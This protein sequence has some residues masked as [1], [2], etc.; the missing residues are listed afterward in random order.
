MENKDTIQG[1]LDRIVYRNKENGFSVFI[2]K[3][4]KKESITVTGCLPSVHD[5]EF[6]VLEGRWGFHKKFGRQFQA[7]SCK[8]KLPSN[9]VGIKKYLGSG[10]IKGIG[11]K[12]AEKLVAVFAEKVLEVIDKEPSRLFEVDGVGPKRVKAI[13]NAWQ[14][15]KEIS[16]IM[17]FLHAR[18]V[19]TAFAVK[20]YK[21]YGQDSIAKIQNNPYQLVEDVWGVGFKTAD[22][23][24]MKLGFEK[25][26]LFRVRAGILYS[27]TES[28]SNGHLYIEIPELKKNVYKVLELEKTQQ[29]IVRDALHDLY[30][31]EKIK[32]ITYSEK[33]FITL[34]Q[35]YFSEKGI[36]NKIKRLNEFGGLYSKFDI[37]SCYQMV[38]KQDEN[39]V[40]LN[41]DQQRGVL[42]CL[43]NK[44]TVITGGPG[45]G[46]TTLIKKLLQV[47]ETYKIKFR[48]AAPTGRAAKRMFE[49]TGRSTETLHRLLEFSPQVM[50]FTRNEQNALDVE[51]VIVDEASMIDLFLMHA[52]LRALPLNAHLIL[53]GDVDQLPSVGVGNILN[54]LILSKKI[55]IIR[56]MHIFRQAQDSLIIVN[57]HRVN[58]G[59]FPLSIKLGSRKD[60][61]YIKEE[62]PEK[63]FSLLR[64][65]Y[66][67]KL[68]RLGIE[69][70]SSIVLSPMNRGLVGTQRLNQELQLILNPGGDLNKQTSRFGQIYKV[71]DRVMQIRNNYDKFVFNGDIGEIED[72]NLVD[73]K[74]IVK[75]DQRSLEY[76]FAELD[77][78]TLSYAVS[79]HKSQGSEF[80]A[81]IIPVFMQHFILLQRN[82]IYTAITRAKRLCILIG[83]SKAIA[84]GIK[85]NKGINRITFLKEYLT[86][87]LEAR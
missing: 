3:V 84:I 86:T 79:I 26:S 35:Y 21:A 5:G 52:L 58:N 80:S 75:F 39:G 4:N 42:A 33:H 77:E 56:L 62:E 57:A 6:V 85:N 43:Q 27:I 20:I 65:I 70:K 29:N 15:Q 48:L 8:S 24:A 66:K 53:L 72:V 81:V 17:V 37:D 41:E 69:E 23:L 47:L 14:E 2:V 63:I 64:V 36:A 7:Q 83:Q 78:I 13:V 10:L 25:Q 32:L 28:F 9:V 31:K 38:R 40:E 55:E 18:E 71:G 73:Q 67:S 12:F 82:L 60:F 87:D 1:N 19:S 76:D 74:M 68:P 46:K 61:I 54:D 51:F 45:T 22:Q 11:P 49:G 30:K 44:I 34:P 16:R 59:E 50:N